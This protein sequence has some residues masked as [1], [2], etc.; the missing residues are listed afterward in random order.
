MPPLLEMFPVEKLKQVS[1]GVFASHIFPRHLPKDFMIRKCKIINI[2]RNPKDVCVSLFNF[3]KK[4]KAGNLMKDMK[5]DVFFGMFIAGNGKIALPLLV[6]LF[7]L[8]FPKCL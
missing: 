3:V 4:T 1:N 6:S 2:Y 7:S 8:F 5:F